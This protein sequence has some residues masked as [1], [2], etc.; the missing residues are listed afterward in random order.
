MQL[1][2]HTPGSTFEFALA[3]EPR[4]EELALSCSAAHHS[5][6]SKDMTVEMHQ[7]AWS[8]SGR[9]LVIVNVELF[10]DEDHIGMA[11]PLL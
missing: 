10:P 8:S 5:G 3:N 1:P 11:T 6:W 7:V 2:L 4:G 9:K